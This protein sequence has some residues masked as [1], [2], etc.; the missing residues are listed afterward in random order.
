MQIT[1]NSNT[2]FK[3]SSTI[4]VI[5]TCNP[6]AKRVLGN[7]FES[8]K[9]AGKAERNNKSIKPGYKDIALFVGKRG[10]S[11]VFGIKIPEKIAD[12]EA[13]V[14]EWMAGLKGMFF[15]KIDYNL[16]EK[17]MRLRDAITTHNI[18]KNFMADAILQ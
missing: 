2:S 1:R 7:Y 5:E 6:D 12:I 11:S 8:L 9:I 13:S 3:N 15:G 14:E 4:R 18:A 10:E 16:I 17:P